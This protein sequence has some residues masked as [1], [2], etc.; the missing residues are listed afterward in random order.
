MPGKIHILLFFFIFYFG[1]TAHLGNLYP[2][3]SSEAGI[4]KI[5]ITKH[6]WHTGIIFSRKAANSYLGALK[7]DFPNVNYLEV[8]W[9]DLDFFTAEKGTV[10]LA[11]KAVLWPTKSVL[12]VMPH[13]NHPFGFFGE[14]ELIELSVSKQ[15][16]INLIQHINNSFAL[17]GDS[18]SIKVEDEIN[19]GGQFY[20]SKEK[21][22]VFKTC[23][24][25]TAKA[26]K[27]TGFPMASTFA[28]TSGNVI[29][30]IKRKK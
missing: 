10:G 20:L 16:F 12:H 29:S 8:G 3:V 17:D 18:L 22:H 2:P 1:C 5:Y 7:E 25:W 4:E 27:K 11:L 26:I 23:N 21:Y 15:G 30:R 6:T 19:I 13:N 24:V 14:G 9:G 28:L